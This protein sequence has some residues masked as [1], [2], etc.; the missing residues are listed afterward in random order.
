MARTHGRSNKNTIR[1]LIAAILAATGTLER[2]AGWLSG[3]TRDDLS[4][5]FKNIHD[6]VGAVPILGI[7]A[8]QTALTIC[9]VL[10]FIVSL[11]MAFHGEPTREE[12]SRE[13]PNP[14]REKRRLEC[15]PCCGTGNVVERR[16]FFFTRK[17]QCKRCNGH[18]SYETDLWSQPDCASCRGDGWVNFYSA[19]F[20]RFY[21]KCLVCDGHGKRPF[22]V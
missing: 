5:A 12:P 6:W 7:P 1:W 18:G 3:A 13:V 10:V 16:A 2:L 11:W 8:V 9:G 4:K 20:T 15:R 22:G 14:L 21:M 19:N 17:E